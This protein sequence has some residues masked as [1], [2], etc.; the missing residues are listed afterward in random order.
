MRSDNVQITNKS[1]LPISKIYYGPL[2][3]ESDQ[4]KI[5]VGSL[6]CQ[7][8]PK[9]QLNPFEN[10]IKD[11][12]LTI[13]IVESN[14]DIMQDVIS[15]YSSKVDNFERWFEDH[16]EEH[17]TLNELIKNQT[18]SQIDIQ[19]EIDEYHPAYQG[20]VCTL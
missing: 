16:S 6:V 10:S 19:V 15:N 5:E 13:Q 1:I 12:N 11:L 2:E 18:E 7:P 3:F 17:D 4:M 8:D 20:K 9:K 14:Q